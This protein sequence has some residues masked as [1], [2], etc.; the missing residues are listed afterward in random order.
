MGE[1]VSAIR[2]RLRRF[3]QGNY[4]IFYEPREKEI[5]LVRVLHGSRRI[6]DLIE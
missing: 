2:P 3:C 6:E 1:A 5:D 4:V